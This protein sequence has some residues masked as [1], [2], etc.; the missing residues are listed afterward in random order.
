MNSIKVKTVWTEQSIGGSGRSIILL[1]TVSDYLVPMPLVLTGP[2]L[3]IC[4]HTAIKWAQCN[5]LVNLPALHPPK[6]TS[7]QIALQF[8]IEMQSYLE[9]QPTSICCEERHDNR[10]YLES[11]ESRWTLKFFPQAVQYIISQS[12]WLIK[13]LQVISHALPTNFPPTF[14]RFNLITHDNAYKLS[15]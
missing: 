11:F 3:H 6:I 7:R 8:H 5:P 10:Q 2:Q 1:W 12:Y 13:G 4:I 14:I 9:T 15:T